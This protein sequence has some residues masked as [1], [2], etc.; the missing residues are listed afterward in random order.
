MVSAGI[1]DF[2]MLLFSS[3]ESSIING[4][5]LGNGVGWWQGALKGGRQE[6]PLQGPPDRGRVPK[7]FPKPTVCLAMF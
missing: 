3:L 1:M 4:L 7:W 2:Q 6:S 5:A